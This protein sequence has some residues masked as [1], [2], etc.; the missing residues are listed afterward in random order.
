MESREPSVVPH[1]L[2]L[3]ART[4]PS[5]QSAW[6]YPAIL[7]VVTVLA[8]G[9]YAI[10]GGDVLYEAEDRTLTHWHEGTYGGNWY[11][12]RTNDQSW[13]EYVAR[14]RLTTQDYI[15]AYVRRNGDAACFAPSFIAEQGFALL[16]RRET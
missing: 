12:N 7:E 5:G 8:T 14:S 15:E 10:L 3:Q 1:R 16:P 9:Q 11:L 6:R 13:T 2:L 4:D